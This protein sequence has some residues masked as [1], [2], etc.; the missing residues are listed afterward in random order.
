M[1]PLITVRGLQKSFGSQTLFSEL[2]FSVQDGERLGILGANGSGKSTLL[3]I[4][5]GQETANAGEIQRMK[6]LRTGWLPQE[7]EL[8]AE[9]SVSAWLLQAL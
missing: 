3:K 1:P 4:L 8:P 2:G 6:G 5:A 9:P 7:E